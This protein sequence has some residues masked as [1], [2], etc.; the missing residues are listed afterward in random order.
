MQLSKPRTTELGLAGNKQRG[1]DQ[2]K[3]RTVDH[4]TRRVI[5]ERARLDMQDRVE[6]LGGVVRHIRQTMTSRG[7]LTSGMTVSQVREAV[8][9]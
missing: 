6:A 7:A 9:G 8:R 3:E 1:S 2:R 5:E 4:E